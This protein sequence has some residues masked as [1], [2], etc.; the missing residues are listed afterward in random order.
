MKTKETIAYQPSLV[1]PLPEILNNKDYNDYR[2]LLESIDEILK[3]SNID[4]EFTAEYLEQKEKIRQKPLSSKQRAKIIREGIVAFRCSLAKIL[5]KKSY[6]ELSVALADSLLLQRFCHLSSLDG[7]LNVPSKSSIERYCKSFKKSSVDE[8][9][10]SLIKCATSS[11][12]VLELEM[13]LEVGDVFIDST[14]IKANIHFPVDWL[15]IKD[16]SYSILQVIAVLRKHGLIHRMRGPEIFMSKLTAL[17]MSMSSET[18]KRSGKVGQRKILRKLNKLAR[19]ILKHGIRYANL[20]QEIGLEVTDLSEDEIKFIALRLNK[21]ITLMPSAIEQASLRILKGEY[22]KNDEKILSAYH[23]DINVIKRGKAGGV[24]EFGNTLF[25]A[26]QENGLIIDW[27]LYK[28]NV[29]D[30]Q[31]TKESIKRMVDDFEYELDSLNSDRGCQSKMNDRLLK[32][33]GIYSGLCPRNPHEYNKK[34]KDERF[35]KLQKRRGQTEARIGILKNSILDGSLYER[36]FDGKDL[37]ISWAI[38]AHNL[39]LLAR[40]PKLEI[41]EEKIAA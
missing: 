5:T 15:L 37:K 9:I 10:R 6:R 12:N 16:C 36:K 24:V 1:N 30:P 40:L 34:L 13:P 41:A 20:L 33:Y 14:C 3:K 31:A 2:N 8:K 35:R 21:M 19:V 27:K 11:D 32:K 22:L 28:D 23:D 18:K 7:V 4:L 17:C 39:W 38:F 26:E 29:K 25:I